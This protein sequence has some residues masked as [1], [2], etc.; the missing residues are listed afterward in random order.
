MGQSSG[1]PYP[2]RPLRRL[3]E[4]LWCVEGAW[5][6]SPFERRM[7][8]LRGRDGSLAVHSG[9][10][11]VEQDRFA[12]R[13]LGEVRWIVVP[14]RFHGSEAAW[15]AAHHAGARVLVPAAL[16]SFF[17][18]RLGRVDGSVEDDEML[19]EI[20]CLS[21]RGTRMHEIALLHAA[22]R[23]LVLT[24]VAFNVGVELPRLARVFMRLNGAYGR[25]GPT[26]LFRWIFLSNRQ[27]FAASL[28]EMLQHPVERIIVSHGAIVETG[29]RE[30]LRRAFA[31]LLR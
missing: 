23:T 11:L 18:S 25:F 9:I 17:E 16:R 12:L 8:I 10:R 26:R 14:N 6:H 31:P 2:Y 29:G 13:E 24:D 4:G 30:V 20:R 3:D 21:L 27:A 5:K 1:Q 15:Y 28:R 22:S 19:P 7:T